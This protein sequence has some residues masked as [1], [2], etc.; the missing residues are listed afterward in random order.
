MGAHR[1]R[2]PSTSRAAALV[3]YTHTSSQ[4]PP[5][6]RGPRR[7]IGR[8]EVDPGQH[9]AAA[10]QLPTASAQ[11][12]PSPTPA[13][14]APWT[15]QTLSRWAR[16]EGPTTA[17]GA[18]RWLKLTVPIPPILTATEHAEWIT[19]KR[20]TATPATRHT[21]YLLGGRVRTPAG[22]TSTPDRRHPK[23]GLRVP[24]PA[25][26]TRHQPR[27]VR[28]PVHPRRDTRRCTTCGGIGL[29]ARP[30]RHG[31][32]TPAGKLPAPSTHA[33][34]TVPQPPNHRPAALLDLTDDTQHATAIAGSDHRQR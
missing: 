26:D 7:T 29:P 11:H 9:D 16:G 25:A 13:S 18:W 12:K 23:S 22:G 32:T 33:T 31:A 21:T 10:G 15:K 30:H 6:T 3:G 17:A 2:G 1:S 4:A 28:V 19:W 20:D 14:G 8:R 24:A 5:P 34:T 27:P